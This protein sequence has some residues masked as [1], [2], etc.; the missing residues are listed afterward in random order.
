MRFKEDVRGDAGED[1]TD[2]QVIPLE[3]TTVKATSKEEAVYDL[4][5]E[6]RAEARKKRK[7]DDGWRNQALMQYGIYKQF[8]SSPESCRATIKKRADKVKSQNPDSP[9]LPYLIELTKKL[10]GLS[11]RESSRYKLLVDHSNKLAG[12][13]SPTARA[14]WFFTEYRET[15][16]ALAESPS[17]RFQNHTVH[18]KVRG[19]GHAVIATVNGSCPDIHFMKIVE[20]F[21][22]ARPICECWSQPTLRAKALTCTTNVIMSFTT[23]TLVHHHACPAQWSHRSNRTT[24]QSSTTLPQC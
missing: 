8:L 7:E 4:L 20:A 16:D 15:Q 19:P 14:S 21:G 1:L 3:A 24:Y 2:R 12:R 18:D 11:I 5:G 10:E 17:Q 23:T 13:A 6:R 22:Q 9:E